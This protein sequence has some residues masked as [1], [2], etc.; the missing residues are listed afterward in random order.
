[1][2]MTWGM[3][4]NGG[5]HHRGKCPECNGETYTCYD[6]LCESCEELANVPEDLEPVTDEA[7]ENFTNRIL[8]IIS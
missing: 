8:N 1:V 3:D 7:A 5:P 6:E 4:Y 2:Q